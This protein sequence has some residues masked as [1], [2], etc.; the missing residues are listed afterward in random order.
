MGS[1]TEQGTG[2]GGQGVNQVSVT[3]NYR[4]SRSLLWHV[5]GGP[6][7]LMFANAAW[8]GWKRG[9][10]LQMNAKNGQSTRAK[11]NIGLLWCTVP[12]DSIDA[13]GDLRGILCFWLPGGFALL[14]RLL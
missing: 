6:D 5:A 3:R 12:R 14:Q 10:Q 1:P 11:N 8:N 9:T 4:N 7:D 2:Q 13:K